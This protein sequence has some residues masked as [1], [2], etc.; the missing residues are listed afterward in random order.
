MPPS[1]LQRYWNLRLDPLDWKRERASLEPGRWRTAHE[2]WCDPATRDALEQLGEL[3]DRRLLEI[4]CGQGHGTLHLS[5]LGARVT[6]IDIAERRCVVARAALASA[7]GGRATRVCAAAADCLPFRDGVFDLVFC[8]DVLM[9][10]DA[11]RVLDECARVL[12]EGGR[13]AFVESLEGGMSL[14]AF[15]RLTSPA[16]YRRFTRHLGWQEMKRLGGPLERVSLRPHYLLSLLA[17]IALFSLGSTAL[18]RL[19]LALLE[20]LDRRLLD[21]VPRLS[22]LAWRATAVYRKPT[23]AA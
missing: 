12:T 13:A 21:L 6:A 10:A 4:G 19:A 22:R 5:R 2:T 3:R 7:G 16:D 18:H 1:T 17:F 14:R 11:E 9:Y 20:P 8:R 15:R 23:H